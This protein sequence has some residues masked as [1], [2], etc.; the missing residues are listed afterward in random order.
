MV[1]DIKNVSKEFENNFVLKN[2]NMRLEGGKIYGFIG[3]NGSGKSVLLKIICGLYRPSLGTV[4]FNNINIV[5]NNMF[6]PNTRA[7]IEKPDFIAELTGLENLEMLASIQNKIGQSEIND[8]LE[9]VNLINEKDKQFGK[10]S[11]GMKQKLGIAQVLMED[12]EVMIFDEPFNGIE[13]ET[14]KKIRKILLK[15][16][17]EGKIIIIASHIKEDMKKLADV[18]F[19]FDEGKVKKI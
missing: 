13:E 18:I 4:F 2:V 10:Y 7:L 12:T 6:A 16:K 3:R 11:L 19:S 14:S 5:E 8:A 17:Q 15:K 9:N 1:I